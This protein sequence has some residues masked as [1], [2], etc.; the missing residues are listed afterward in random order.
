MVPRVNDEVIFSDAFIQSVTGLSGLKGKKIK[1]MSMIMKSISGSLIKYN[2][3]YLDGKMLKTLII[4]MDSN[5]NT[6]NQIPIFTSST[7]TNNSNR[8]TISAQQIF[9]DPPQN[10]RSEDDRCKKCGSMGELRGMSCICPGCGNVV[11]GI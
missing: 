8:I 2:M 5:G 1:I 3:A 9:I 7:G 4:E 11:W 10:A 6:A